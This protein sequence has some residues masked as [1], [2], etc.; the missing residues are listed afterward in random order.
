MSIG[1]SGRLVIEIDPEVKQ[2]LYAALERDGLTL[3]DW[4]VRNVNQYLSGSG[5]LALTFG[6][7]S[8]QG[9]RQ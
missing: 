5:Q 7:S 3:K 6:D 4:F 1:K 8:E 9:V 2:Q